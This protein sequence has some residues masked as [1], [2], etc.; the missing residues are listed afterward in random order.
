VTVFRSAVKMFVWRTDDVGASEDNAGCSCA[1]STIS[2][3][4]SAALESMTRIRWCALTR[5]GGGSRRGRGRRV[6]TLRPQHAPCA[7]RRCSHPSGGTLGLAGRAASTS[8]G[9]S[10]GACPQR[11]ST[12]GSS[13]FVSWMRRGGMRSRRSC[14]CCGS[15]P[16]LAAPPGL[17]FAETVGCS[18]GHRAWRGF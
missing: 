5:G 11:P 12:H 10:E 6:S 9:R 18:A 17:A 4:W 13:R 2:R 8:D 16:A 7:L 15:A 3:R 14:P 1:G